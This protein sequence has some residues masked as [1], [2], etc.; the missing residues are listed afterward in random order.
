MIYRI[1]L[2]PMILSDLYGQDFTVTIL[3]N[4]K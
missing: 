3:F 1:V 2:F 4:V